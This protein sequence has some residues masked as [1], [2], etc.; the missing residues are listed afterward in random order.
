MTD[1][2]QL[3]RQRG[4]EPLYVQVADQI[5]RRIEAGELRPDDRVPSEPELVRDLGVSRS[6]AR[7]A[8]EH[9]VQSGVVR[10]EQGRGSFVQSATLVQRRPELGS[11]SESVRHNGQVP[12]QRLVRYEDVDPESEPLAVHFA[13]GEPIQRLVRLRLVDG[14]AVGLHRHLLAASVAEAA[15]VSE[16]SLAAPDASLFALFG[17]AGLWIAEADE[18]LRAI[19]ASDED[20]DLL[21][22][23]PGT[24]LMRVLRVSYDA[25]GVPLEVADARYVG[26]RIDYHVSL[27]RPRV[28][29]TAHPTEGQI[30]HE[31]HPLDH[32]DGDGRHRPRGL[33]LR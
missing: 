33:R 6:T 12:E 32:A 30:D 11:F 31:K 8:L 19:A 27:T 21:S 18:H 4:T 24:P 25:R 1:R 16:D 13:G 17:A 20:A 3:I 23:A 5:L 29:E 15:G 10:R 22:V 9:L 14:E 26:D 2:T 7:S 28:P